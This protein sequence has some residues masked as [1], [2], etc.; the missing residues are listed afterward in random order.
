MTQGP[1]TV[2]SDAMG[3]PSP[4]DH[5]C[6]ICEAEHR[7]PTIAALEMMFGTRE[8]FDY[9]VCEACRTLQIASIPQDLA[10]YYATTQYYSFNNVAARPNPLKRWLKSAAASL[11]VGRPERY[12]RGAGPLDRIARASE[13][14]ISVVPGLSKSSAILDVGCGEGARLQ[15]LAALGFRNLTGI[16]PFLPKDLADRMASGVRLLKGELEK[17]QETFDC[18]MF[19]HSLEHVPDP[20]ETLRV[21]ARRLNPGGAILVRIPLF[22][23]AIW[24]RFGI[25]WAQMDP[26]RHLYLFA[27]QGFIDFARREGFETVVHGYDMMGWSLA[28]SEAYRQG[29]PMITDGKPNPLPFDRARLDAFEA[30]ARALNAS[31][32]ADQGYFVSKPL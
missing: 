11:I 1:N 10:Q 28:W 13:P 24:E 17:R 32:G 7:G 14:W 16:D 5:V 29:I 26:P 6:R 4:A 25:D 27:P 30:E 2:D 22:Q 18:I 3:L 9:F 12:P 20:G 23:P 15:S 8:M 31:G 21:A 19:H